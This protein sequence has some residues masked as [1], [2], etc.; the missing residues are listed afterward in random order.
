MLKLAVIFTIN[1]FASAVKNRGFYG[2]PNDA[3]VVAKWS[4]TVPG[5]IRAKANMLI[6]R[7]SKAAYAKNA[8]T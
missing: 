6:N 5:I 4:A 2:Y 7:K 1:I 3:A 8:V